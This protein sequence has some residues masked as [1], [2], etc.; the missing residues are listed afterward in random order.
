MFCAWF[1]RTHPTQECTLTS[2][3]STTKKKRKLAIHPSTAA[4]RSSS[5]RAMAIK[6]GTSPIQISQGWCTGGNA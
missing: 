1:S 6:S 2:G 4:W 3:C 5:H